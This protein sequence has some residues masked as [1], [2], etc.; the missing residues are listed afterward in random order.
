MNI[1]GFKLVLKDV[2]QKKHKEQIDVSQQK[3][4]EVDEMR[5]RLGMLYQKLEKVTSD[6]LERKLE[7]DIV[8][9]DKEIELR[10]CERNQQRQRSMILLLTRNT[11][12]ISWNTQEKYY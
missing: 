11:Q 1:E 5:T 6:K 4:R 12:N 9:L 10:E 2:N 8:E 3:A 7:T